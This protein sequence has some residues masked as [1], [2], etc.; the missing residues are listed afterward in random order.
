MK[1]PIKQL[2]TG[3]L[4]LLPGLACAHTLIRVGGKM[5]VHDD[6]STT[7]ELEVPTIY[8]YQM[9]GN[10]RILL[11]NWGEIR[12]QKDNICQGFAEK[13]CLRI[14]GRELRPDEVVLPTL[15]TQTRAP[16][17]SP[18][19]RHVPVRAT[20]H[21]TGF[22][23]SAF[24]SNTPITH[25]PTAKETIFELVLE[26]L[27]PWWRSAGLAAGQGF[28]HM[29]T[30]NAGLLLLILLLG[31]GSTR[32]RDLIL[33]FAA[34]S[35]THCLALALAMSDL[36]VSGENWMLL[37]EIL[38]ALSVTFLALENT[39]CASPSVGRRLVLTGLLGLINGIGFN[40]TLAAIPW[41]TGRFLLVLFAA[42]F[43]L[44]LAQLTM[45][46]LVMALLQRWKNRSWYRPALSIPLGILAGLCGL[47]RAW[48]CLH[49]AIVV[50]F[51]QGL[52]AFLWHFYLNNIWLTPAF[53]L[54]LTVV[55]LCYLYRF[56]VIW[57]RR[58]NQQNKRHSFW[59]RLDFWWI[60]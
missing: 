39:R 54:T 6:T 1:L 40:E 21:H 11:S 25:F 5:E 26:K 44:G 10:A 20:W 7:L 56:C 16:D 51:I 18:P 4:L 42:S 35:A 29:I 15:P 27:D 36:L 28:R 38:I 2:A 50:D 49:R 58:I 13:I 30:S 9:A 53:V 41:P 31:L 33:Q 55:L 19:P 23:H 17:N 59:R 34:F 14:M 47:H 48:Q 46:G 57:Q 22:L 60:K 37:A 24:E 12:D 32:P 8:L 52:G 43:G 45:G 3:L